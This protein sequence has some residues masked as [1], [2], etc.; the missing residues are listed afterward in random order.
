MTGTTLFC[1]TAL[2]LLAIGFSFRGFYYEW[3]TKRR[4]VKMKRIED[5]LEQLCREISAYSTPRLTSEHIPQ[6]FPSKEA[7][8]AFGEKWS[9]GVE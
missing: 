4:A 6:R 7:A 9:R 8:I 1:F 2:I 3:Q 5:E